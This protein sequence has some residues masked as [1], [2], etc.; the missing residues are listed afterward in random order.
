MQYQGSVHGAVVSGFECAKE[1]LGILRS[2]KGQQKAEDILDLESKNSCAGAE[3]A[4]DDDE[5]EL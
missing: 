2:T 1:C 4:E 3:A 5:D